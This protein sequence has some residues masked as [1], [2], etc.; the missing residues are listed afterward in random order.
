MPC[1]DPANFINFCTGKTL[2]N[3]LQVKSGSCNGVVMGD[4]PSSNNMISTLILFP[5]AESKLKAGQTFKI[6]LRTDN[7]VA[8][9]FTSKYIRMYIYRES[10]IEL[11]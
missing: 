9:H 8:G 5:N 10:I 1:S 6:T 2:T 4:I 11:Y 3:G 7:L